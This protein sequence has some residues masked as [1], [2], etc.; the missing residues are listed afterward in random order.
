LCKALAPI[1]VCIALINWRRIERKPAGDIVSR[2]E[3]TTASTDIADAIATLTLRKPR[4]FCLIAVVPS[5]QTLT[6]RRWNLEWLAA[7]AHPSKAQHWFSSGFDERKP[8]SNDAA[9]VS[10]RTTDNCLRVLHG[11]RR[12]HR[13]HAAEPGPFSNCMHRA[14]AGTVSYTEVAVSPKWLVMRYKNGTPCSTKS[15]ITR[16]L[17]LL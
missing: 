5:E 3:V 12:L 13:S 10:R 2:G 14:G 16:A 4:P 17:P 6:A 9:C 7:R 1:G 11:M 15:T 8:K